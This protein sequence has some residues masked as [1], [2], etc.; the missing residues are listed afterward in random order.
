MDGDNGPNEPGPSRTIAGGPH[1]ISECM[2]L[3]P[4]SRPRDEDEDSEYGVRRSISCDQLAEWNAQ[5]YEKSYVKCPLPNCGIMFHGA[6]QIQNHYVN[7]TGRCEDAIIECNHCQ[8]IV[9]T[10]QIQQHL[11]IMHCLD[12]SPQPSSDSGSSEVARATGIM[13]RECRPNHKG[14]GVGSSVVGAEEEEGRDFRLSENCIESKDHHSFKFVN[15]D[16]VE[17]QWVHEL[18]TSGCATCPVEGCHLTFPSMSGI[19][20]HFQHCLGKSQEAFICDLCS[21]RFATCRMLNDHKMHIHGDDRVNIRI[22][23]LDANV[24]DYNVRRRVVEGEDSERRRRSGN[25]QVFNPMSVEEEVAMKSTNDRQWKQRDYILLSSTL[26]PESSLSDCYL[27]QHQTSQSVYNVPKNHT[28]HRDVTGTVPSA[29]NIPTS[30]KTHHSVPKPHRLIDYEKDRIPDTSHRY[31]PTSAFQRVKDKNGGEPRIVKVYDVDSQSSIR[32]SGYPETGVI[33]GD[34]EEVREPISS[35]D[36]FFRPT[37]SQPI[38]SYVRK[39]GTRSPVYPST[40]GV[41]RKYSE[42]HCGN[43]YE[44]AKSRKY[45]PT[46]SYTAGYTSDES[47]EDGR[48]HPKYERRVRHSPVMCSYPRP[49]VKTEVY[50]AGSRPVRRDQ[51]YNANLT[52]N[53][54]APYIS[55]SKKESTPTFERPLLPEESNY[56]NSK[57]NISCMWEENEDEMFAAPVHIKKRELAERAQQLRRAEEA[58]KQQE[59]EA[60]QRTW[61]ALREQELA[62]KEKEEALKQREFA[63]QKKFEEATRMMEETRKLGDSK[64]FKEDKNFASGRPTLLLSVNKRSNSASSYLSNEESGNSIFIG[65]VSDVTK[66]TDSSLELQD[67]MQVENDSECVGV[68]RVSQPESFAHEVDHSSLNDI[69]FQRLG[70]SSV[71][72]TVLNIKTSSFQDENGLSKSHKAHSLMTPL[73]PVCTKSSSTLILSGN[74]KHTYPWQISEVIPSIEPSK[75]VRTYSRMQRRRTLTDSF[76]HTSSNAPL[77]AQSLTPNSK[78]FIRGTSFEGQKED[79]G[80]TS[81]E[82][83]INGGATVT[84]IPLMPSERPRRPYSAM[85]NLQPSGHTELPESSTLLRSRPTSALENRIDIPVSITVT[86]DDKEISVDSPINL[87]LE[88]VKLPFHDLKVMSADSHPIEKEKNKMKNI[89]VHEADKAGEM[90]SKKESSETY[91]TLEK[92]E[93]YSRGKKGRK[94]SMISLAGVSIPGQLPTEST[95]KTGI[96]CHGNLT[97]TP[98]LQIFKAKPL[99]LGNSNEV[100]KIHNSSEEDANMKISGQYLNTCL[101]LSVAKSKTQRNVQDTKP[102]VAT[103]NVLVI[104]EQIA[105]HSAKRILVPYEQDG[106]SPKQDKFEIHPVISSSQSLINLSLMNNP[107]S[108]TPPVSVESQNPV[109]GEELPNSNT[110]EPVQCDQTFITAEEESSNSRRNSAASPCTHS[111]MYM[112]ASSPHELPAKEDVIYSQDKLLE[113]H[114][115]PDFVDHP[116]DE[117]SVPTQSTIS[118]QE[119]PS[120]GER[121]VSVQE[122]PS[123][124]QNTNFDLAGNDLLHSQND[125]PVSENDDQRSNENST[126]SCSHD[127]K[128]NEDLGSHISGQEPYFGDEIQA[129]S[130]ATPVNTFD[131]TSDRQGAVEMD[132]EHNILIHEQ[133]AGEEEFIPGDGKQE[134]VVQTSQEIGQESQIM[135][136]EVEQTC[137]EQEIPEKEWLVQ[138]QEWHLQNKGNPRNDEKLGME[139]T[140]QDISNFAQLQELCSSLPPT[141]KTNIEVEDSSQIMDKEVTNTFITEEQEHQEQGQ[142]INV[143]QIKSEVTSVNMNVTVP[144]GAS[145]IIGEFDPTTGTFIS[146]NPVLL[147][148]I[149]GNTVTYPL[150]SLSE[151]TFPSEYTSQITQQLPVISQ[152]KQVSVQSQTEEVQGQVKYPDDQC[153][154]VEGETRSDFIVNNE[155]SDLEEKHSYINQAYSNDYENQNVCQDDEVVH[156]NLEQ[157]NTSFQYKM[158]DTFTE[159]SNASSAKKPE[160]DDLG[161]D[162]DEDEDL[163]NDADTV[164]AEDTEV[165]DCD[166]STDVGINFNS[167]NCLTSEIKDNY[168]AANTDNQNDHLEMPVA[169]NISD[170]ALRNPD[171]TTIYPPIYVSL[172]IS[173]D[174]AGIVHEKIKREISGDVRDDQ[175]EMGGVEFNGTNIISPPD[176]TDT[177]C[178]AQGYEMVNCKVQELQTTE[179][180]DNNLSINEGQKTCIEMHEDNNISFNAHDEFQEDDHETRGQETEVSQENILVG[181]SRGKGRGRGKSRRRGYRRGRARSRAR[182]RGRAKGSRSDTIVCAFGE[183]EHETAHRNYSKVEGLDNLFDEQ[184]RIGEKIFLDIS[185]TA[186]MEVNCK[187][188]DMPKSGA[189][190][191]R[192]KEIILNLNSGKCV[193][194]QE[195]STILSPPKHNRENN[196]CNMKSPGYMND[197]TCKTSIGSDFLK[198]EEERIEHVSRGGR[199]LKLKDWWTGVVTD[200]LSPRSRTS[201]LSKSPRSSSGRSPIRSPP[202]SATPRQLLFVKEER[203]PS[204]SQECLENDNSFISSSQMGVT[205]TSDTDFQDITTT[206]DNNMSV[207]RETLSDSEDLNLSPKKRGRLGKTDGGVSPVVEKIEIK[208]GKC[209]TICNSNSSFMHHIHIEHNGLARPDGEDQTFTEIETKERLKKAIKA[210]RKLKCEACSHVYI[211]LLGYTRHAETCGK[212]DEEIN[213]RCSICNKEMRYYSVASHMRTVHT[214]RKTDPKKSVEAIS[215]ATRPRRRAAANCNERLKVWRSNRTGESGSDNSD[216]EEDFN[217]ELEADKFYS[218]PELVDVPEELILKWESQLSTG[219][220]GCCCNEGCAFSFSSIPQAKSHFYLCPY[221]ASR[222]MF[223]CKNCDYTSQTEKEMVGHVTTIHIDLTGGVEEESDYDIS[224]DDCDD[225]YRQTKSYSRMGQGQLKPFEPAMKWTS[226]FY[227]DSVSDALFLEY[228]TTKDEWITLDEEQSQRFLPSV[229]QSP[230]FKVKQAGRVTNSMTGEWINIQQFTGQSVGGT[231]VIFCGGP[232]ISSAWCPLPQNVSLAMSPQYL[233]LSTLKSPEKEYPILKSTVHEGLIQI[234]EC[235]S[236]RKENHKHLKFIFGIAHDFGNVWSLAWCPSGAYE[237]IEGELAC[238]QLKRL[239]LLA[240]AF[241]DGFIRIYVIPHPSDLGLHQEAKIFRLQPKVTLSPGK[242]Y[243]EEAQCLHLDWYQGKGHADIAGALSDGVVCVWDI[244]CKSPLLYVKDLYDNFKIYPRNSFQAHNGVCSVVAFCNTTGGRNLVTGGNDR[245]YKF[246]DLENTDMP[247]CI[248][249]KGL[250]LDAVW[251]RHWAGCFV[252][253]DDVYG[254]SNTSTSFRECGFFGIQSRNVLSSNAPVWSLAGSEWLN[255]V[256]QGDASGEVVVTIQQ[257][258]FRNYENDKFPSK[259]KVPLLSVRLEDLEQGSAVSF[260]PQDPKPKANEKSNSKMNKKFKK[261]RPVKETDDFDDDGDEICPATYTEWPHTYVDTCQ[262]YGIVFTDQNTQDFSKIPASEMAERKRSNSMEPGPVSC[263]PLMAATSVAWN[264]NLGAHTWIFVGTQSGLCKVINVSAL[265]TTEGEKFVKEHGKS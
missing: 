262:K 8:A 1:F 113:E 40:S 203:R 26:E 74:K 248:N 131:N 135:V 190:N 241:S 221:S 86:K 58:V 130:P 15:Q 188:H 138:D 137:Q 42:E 70:G 228:F 106:V 231:D 184:S 112:E 102:G 37:H 91:I 68:A 225:S 6:T 171:N 128:E 195:D 133:D 150:A 52:H 213:T 83:V 237:Y 2:D 14:G 261:S 177:N 175:T 254:L 22:R 265:N 5:L 234:W 9:T 90:I 164:E 11:K 142:D 30:R 36:P 147:K 181:Q 80:K 226:E 78:I 99:D 39:I 116:E 54:K 244:R 28:H 47:E 167:N 202:Y 27:P 246:W 201:S 31:E 85:P 3:V 264:N 87:H 13:E 92:G 64:K 103:Q 208:C 118:V 154:S 7:C 250:V 141:S 110:Q 126:A 75:V 200:S 62:L 151:G 178:T 156:Q 33:Y 132:V 35:E 179:E 211:S 109:P 205:I 162:E 124:V 32:I 209:G 222:Q 163:G 197:S 61:R 172:G 114:V 192:K 144:E 227:K 243:K 238:G 157:M 20:Q 219:G 17:R 57:C 46:V 252:S 217:I 94:L 193:T 210:V 255:A 185:S 180:E 196:S 236:A 235:T 158:E 260:K 100:G 104:R 145:H 98:S 239:G 51:S 49:I 258:L 93:P 194:D 59:E 129:P 189:D 44:T 66:R 63:A 88:N 97:S 23:N 155:S 71:D 48:L 176:T 10:D 232:I 111:S 224:D 148:S 25:S 43:V 173:E 182:G 18:S 125:T 123:P 38:R 73:S 127:Q 198:V 60:Q 170:T 117:Q 101:D 212:S 186:G 143:S 174:N 199:K 220:E 165:A 16:Q 96:K 169:D 245:T 89:L 24:P 218:K 206:S 56:G 242:M 168:C 21:K 122:E 146:S 134:Q 81:G 79:N 229:K 191:D 55:F 76:P 207:T 72:R 153:Y 240:A 19:I 45:I 152:V 161:I 41:K 214:I 34:K 230:K 263:Y 187:T 65:S 29:Y 257:Q 216:A 159:T 53:M 204:T 82:T 233:A 215:S 249:R 77:R 50:P 183:L 259:R 140:I 4:P 69:S 149:L 247:L 12:Q 107:A 120:P 119:E 251:L 139:N 256:V 95:W 105:P 121:Q 115:R 84:I 160:N 67:G 253:F 166:E 108:Q 223:M 136:Q